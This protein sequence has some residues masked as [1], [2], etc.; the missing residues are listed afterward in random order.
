MADGVVRNANIRPEIGHRR[1]E[2]D[3]AFP[4]ARNGD[5]L[6]RV[7][8]TLQRPNEIGLLRIGHRR[9]HHVILSVYSLPFHV[10]LRL[11]CT[12]REQPLGLL[13][14]CPNV[15]I[16][17]RWIHVVAPILRYC[18]VLVTLFK[19]NIKFRRRRMNSCINI[20]SRILNIVPEFGLTID[21]ISFSFYNILEKFLND[22]K[23]IEFSDKKKNIKNYWFARE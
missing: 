2:A 14:F 1:I 20:H 13:W 22:L 21:D 10:T 19:V 18:L 16:Y 4:I 12:R 6:Q 9:A 7:I 8:V 5:L 11:N 17:T 15:S 23:M 3:V